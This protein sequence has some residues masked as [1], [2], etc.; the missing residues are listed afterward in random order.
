MKTMENKH[1]YE[2]NVEWTQDRKG[3]ISSPVLN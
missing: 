1:Q 3:I 2:V